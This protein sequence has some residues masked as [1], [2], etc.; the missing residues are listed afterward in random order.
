L[1]EFAKLS[2][3][4]PGNCHAWVNVMAL[5]EDYLKLLVQIS[6]FTE[7][8][9]GTSIVDEY[10]GPKKLSQ[11]NRARRLLTFIGSMENS[12]SENREHASCK[13]GA[14]ATVQR[15]FFMSLNS[16]VRVFDL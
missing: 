8:V 16:S 9:R 13:G 2:Y 5:G 11:E 4:R 12:V 7:E 15:V 14:D 3:I 1:C 6:N 10:F